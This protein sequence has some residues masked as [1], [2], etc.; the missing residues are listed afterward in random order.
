MLINFEFSTPNC[1]AIEDYVAGPEIGKGAYAE[2]IE[3]KHKVTLEK[4]AIKKYDRYK[5]LDLQRKKQAIREIKILSKLSHPSIVRL[6]E[7]IDS[8]KYVYLVMEYAQGMSL[9]AHLKSAPNRQ[10]G[11]EKAKKII[12]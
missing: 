5:L 7:A 11:E 10:F 6:H 8:S 1:G 12:K 2:V 4:V 9:H 3:A